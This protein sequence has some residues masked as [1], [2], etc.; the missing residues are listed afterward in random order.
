[1]WILLVR[2]IQLGIGLQGFQIDIVVQL[3][4]TLHG[5]RIRQIELATCTY[6]R[7]RVI[8]MFYDTQLVFGSLTC[9]LTLRAWIYYTGL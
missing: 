9:Q 1:M 2:I 7:I 3:F 6:I 4:I 8:N 5:F